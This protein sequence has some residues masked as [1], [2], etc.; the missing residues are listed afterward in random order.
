MIRPRLP[1]WSWLKLQQIAVKSLL[2][3]S[4]FS[5]SGE[6]MLTTPSLFVFMALCYALNSSTIYMRKIRT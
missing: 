3:L 2:K 5:L 4:K 1:S 6:F